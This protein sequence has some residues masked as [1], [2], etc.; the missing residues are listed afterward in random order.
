VAGWIVI[1][2]RARAWLEL[3]RVSNAP[4]V[5][6][7]ALTGCALAVQGDAAYP[8]RAFALAAPALVLIYVAGMATNDVIDAATDRTERPGRPIPSGRVSRA[9]AG[10]FAIVATSAAL[11]LLAAA[12]WRA[13]VAGAGLSLCALVYNAT[14]RFSAATVVLMAACRSL[15]VVTAACTA[16]GPPDWKPVLIVAGILGVYV[17]ALSAV[18][19]GEA[20]SRKRIRIVVAMVCAISLIDAAVLAVIQRF[21]QAAIAVGCFA[22][23]AWGQRR[24]LGS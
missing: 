14:H 18:A 13:G 5:A 15:A 22:L 17:I 2:P 19:R 11:A 10:W 4:T 9:A 16:G 20:G 6:S 23:S 7:N 8:W 21:V 1:P 12:D 24:I 3:L